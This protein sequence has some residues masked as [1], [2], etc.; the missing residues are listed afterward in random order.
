[1]Q[2]IAKSF[3]K[4][5]QF[6][7]DMSKKYC[8]TVLDEIN[9]YQPKTVKVAPNELREFRLSS[10]Q[11]RR[12]TAEKFFKQDFIKD[13][14]DEKWNIEIYNR[15]AF[16]RLYELLGEN[17]GL[18]YQ[19]RLKLNQFKTAILQTHNPYKAL[20]VNFRKYPYNETVNEQVEWDE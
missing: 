5:K 10:N 7:A 16:Y 18:S 3:E 6:Y 17:E 2:S 20:G 8:P 11:N 14:I 4:N 1:M 19:I 9:S 13:Y 15:D 12:E